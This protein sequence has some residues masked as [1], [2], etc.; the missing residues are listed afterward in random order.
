M[1]FWYFSDFSGKNTVLARKKPWKLKKFQ[2]FSP[3]SMKKNFKVLFL[4]F[5]KISVFRVFLFWY[6]SFRFPGFID[7]YF[8]FFKKFLVTG[9]SPGRTH[10]IPS[11]KNISFDIWSDVHIWSNVLPQKNVGFEFGLRIQFYTFW[12]RNQILKFSD[13]FQTS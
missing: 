2:S 1:F 5:I 10:K 6:K 3:I 4:Y 7:N 11:Q 13:F 8:S 12:Y 9:F